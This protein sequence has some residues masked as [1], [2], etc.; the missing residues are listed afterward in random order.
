MNQ[1]LPMLAVYETI[2]LGLFSALRTNGCP[3]LLQANHPVFFPDPLHDDTIYVY[4]AFGVHV[5]QMGPVLQHLA[6][7]LREEDDDAVLD[8]TLQ[9]P[10]ETLVRPLL[11]TFSVERKCVDFV[12]TFL[13]DVDEIS[14][15]VEPYHWHLFTQRR[16]SQLQ[17]PHFILVYAYLRFSSNAAFRFRP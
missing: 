8:S 15:V 1:D 13:R 12:N 3:D 5:L 4:H 9:T 6:T 17:H 2:D 7:A 10:V 11:T 16:L 14:Q